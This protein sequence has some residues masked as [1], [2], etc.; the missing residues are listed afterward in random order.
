MDPT[1]RSIPLGLSLAFILASFAR[2]ALASDR[3]PPVMASHFGADGV[4][5]GFQTRGSFLLTCAGIELSIFV[6]FALLP[7]LM[8]ALPVQ[9]INFPHK[10]YWL[11]PE[12]KDHTLKRAAVLF[13]W[14]GFATVAMMVVTFELALRANLGHSQLDSRAMWVLLAAYLGFSV[15]WLV[16][17]WRAFP[18]PA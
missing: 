11:A 18:A 15:S 9:L 3:L 10:E 17:L 4:A 13:D 16:R 7:M 2:M 12:R 8:N 1:R 14:F 6:L 5:N